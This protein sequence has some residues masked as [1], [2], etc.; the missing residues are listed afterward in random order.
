MKQKDMIFEHLASMGFEPLEV[1]ATGLL[2]R[3]EEYSYLY[4]PDDDDEEY[5][6]VAIPQLFEVTDDNRSEVL[7]VT[8]E[9]NA[10]MK[11]SKFCI[12]YGTTVWALYEHKLNPADNIQELLE[13]IIRVLGFSA[14]V[15][16]LRMNGEDVFSGMDE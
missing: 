10:H 9:V 1:D 2:F 13:H 4:I 8:Q 11:Y 16:Y 15:F 14:N 6:R 12:M 3:H 7:E 5:L